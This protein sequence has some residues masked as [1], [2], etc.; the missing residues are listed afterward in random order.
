MVLP[1]KIM[2]YDFPVQQLIFFLAGKEREKK[3]NDAWKKK[4]ERKRT[5]RKR[6]RT[7]TLPLPRLLLPLSRPPETV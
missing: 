6:K 3:R 2:G 1:G 7:V 5:P 4:R